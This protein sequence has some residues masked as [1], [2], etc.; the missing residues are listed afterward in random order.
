MRPEMA[1]GCQVPM[2]GGRALYFMAGSSRR[3][4]LYRWRNRLTRSVCGEPLTPRQLL[5]FTF[6]AQVFNRYILRKVPSP[7][8]LL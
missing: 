8:R 2:I 5:L 6:T 3:A 7:A 1:E 4:G